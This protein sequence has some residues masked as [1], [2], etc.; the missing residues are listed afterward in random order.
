MT[1][2]PDPIAKNDLYGMLE[3]LKS[4][5]MD[6]AVGGTGT[7]ATAEYAHI[8]RVLLEHPRVQDRLPP[9]IKKYRT[10]DEFWTYIKAA[11]K[12]YA[13]RRT[14]LAEQFNPLLDHLE[15]N[16][17]DAM[18]SFDAGPVIGQGGFGV[19]YKRKH[20][21]LD[22]YFAFKVFAPAFESPQ[23]SDNAIARFFQEARILFDLRSPYIISIYDVGMENKRPFIQME[24]F[25][26]INLDEAIRQYGTIN[27]QKALQIIKCVVLAI[28]D[29]HEKGILHRDLKPSNIMI[30][31]G[32]QLRVIDFGLGVYVENYL[33]SRITKTG[34]GVAGG[35]YT[36]PELLQDPKIKDFRCDIYSIGAIWYYLLTGRPP[37]GADIRETL[38]RIQ[39]IPSDHRDAVIQ[40]LLGC[41]KRLSNCSRL[42]SLLEQ[43]EQVEQV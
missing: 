22:K 17:L 10:I 38:D 28:R 3:T 5:L 11:H 37:A 41:E 16:N 13:E 39:Q 43:L 34:H 15:S 2:L 42:L 24:F 25:D 35:V 8:R 12:T 33:T 14:F 23:D 30:K 7:L 18:A 4:C 27:Y 21:L 6:K 31:P 9:F 36:A 26:G 1:T 19:V 29:A 40:C 20:K 32:Q